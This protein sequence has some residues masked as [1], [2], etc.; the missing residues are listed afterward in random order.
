MININPAVE[1][2]AGGYVGE[3]EHFP[4]SE[5][6]REVEEAEPVGFAD[7]PHIHRHSAS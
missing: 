1:G 5:L 2:C 3:G 7:R 4:L 6:A